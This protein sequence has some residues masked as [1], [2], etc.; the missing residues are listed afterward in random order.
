M[1]KIIQR[2]EQKQ[3]LNPKQILESSI[4]QLNSHVLEK[5]ILEEVENNPTLDIDEEENQ[6]EENDNSEIQMGIPFGY[7]NLNF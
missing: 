1:S 7:R 5:R 3:R 6:I 2:L 4:M